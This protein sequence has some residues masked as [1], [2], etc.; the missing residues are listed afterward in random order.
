M[1]DEYHLGYFE[2]VRNVALKYMMEEFEPY[3]EQ[4]LQGELKE[5]L[6]LRDES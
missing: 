4:W 6:R 5:A 1:T 3:F 2:G